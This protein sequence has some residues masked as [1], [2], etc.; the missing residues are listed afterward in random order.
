MPRL[1]KKYRIQNTTR[2]FQSSNYEPSDKIL[3]FHLIGGSRFARHID[4]TTSDGRRLTM[5]I[6]LNPDWS[7]SL[8][9]ALRLTPPTG[10]TYTVFGDGKKLID[11]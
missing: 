3:I 4:N 2:L 5:L 7:V 10:E 11:C 6:Y 1:N 9:G 8:G